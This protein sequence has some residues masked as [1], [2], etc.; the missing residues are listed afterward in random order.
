MGL[1]TPRRLDRCI[2]TPLPIAA[3]R[4]EE[5]W[6]LAMEPS[7]LCLTPNRRDGKGR[8]DDPGRVRRTGRWAL[9]AIGRSRLDEWEEWIGRNAAQARR[10]LLDP[11]VRVELLALLGTDDS[12]Q[13]QARRLEEARRD[14]ASMELRWKLAEDEVSEP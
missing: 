8:S 3:I 11:G 2:N 9:P 4:S 7:Y 5:G 13:R 1:H 12:A 14:L 6:L 10:A